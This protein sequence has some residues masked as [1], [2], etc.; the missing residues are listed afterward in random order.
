M[1]FNTIAG[2]AGQLTYS[3]VIFMGRKTMLAARV[4]I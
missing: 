4:K 3:N 2:L 1:F